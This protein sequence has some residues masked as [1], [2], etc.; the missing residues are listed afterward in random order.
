MI[1]SSWGWFLQAI[2]GHIGYRDVFFGC[3]NKKY[4]EVVYTINM[5]KTPFIIHLGHS[6]QIW[7]GHVYIGWWCP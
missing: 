1:D 2:C 5:M 6:Q 4:L 3:Q 7:T